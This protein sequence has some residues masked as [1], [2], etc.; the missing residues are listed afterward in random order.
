MSF[1]I[2]FNL[3]RG[4]N[5]Q[6][7]KITNN[8]NKESFYLTP[9]EFNLELIGCTLRNQKGTAERIYGGENKT[10]C[11]WVDCEDILVRSPKAIEGD[12]VKYNP[13]ENPNWMFKGENADKQK[14]KVLTTCK[15]NIICEK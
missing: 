12:L 15:R 3:G 6:K 8:S 9:E 10:V 14:F 7:W 1:K 2:R 4:D 5:F 13:R 11:A